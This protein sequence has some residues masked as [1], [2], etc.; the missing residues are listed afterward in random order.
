MFN[1]CLFWTHFGHFPGTFLIRPVL[2]IPW[3]LD[4]IINWNESPPMFLKWIIIWIE[5]WSAII[6]SDIE[7]N[8]LLPKF[9]HWIESNGT[10]F[11]TLLTLFFLLQLNLM[12]HILI[13]LG[14]LPKASSYLPRF[15]ILLKDS[16]L[17]SCSLWSP[18]SCQIENSYLH[19]NVSQI[20]KS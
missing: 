16:Q 3:H 1:F 10:S 7:L 13:F 9:K 12:K 17:S 5:F 18:S 11:Q 2:M 14:L 19:L 4:W 8:Q 15:F 6:E 20:F